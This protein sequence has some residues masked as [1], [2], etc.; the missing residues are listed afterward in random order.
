MI[1]KIYTALVGVHTVACATLA[2]FSFGVSDS[3]EVK[4]IKGGDRWV[5]DE[6]QKSLLKYCGTPRQ[7]EWPTSLLEVLETC[8]VGGVSTKE[9]EEH[10]L[11]KFAKNKNKWLFNSEGRKA[12]LILQALL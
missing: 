5:P 3:F 9:L 12:G 2:K 7:L 11:S 8:N 6:D 1:W 10:V 4:C